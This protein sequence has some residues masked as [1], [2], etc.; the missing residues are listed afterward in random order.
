MKTDHFRRL[1]KLESDS[2]SAIQRT[3]VIIFGRDAKDVE[4][5]KATYPEGTPFLT[6]SWLPPTG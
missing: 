5:Q 2:L 1:S 4:A 6:L 3:P